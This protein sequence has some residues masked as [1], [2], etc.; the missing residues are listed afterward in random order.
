ME[1]PRQAGADDE[2]VSAPVELPEL[3]AASELPDGPRGTRF[4]SA[5]HEILEHTDFAAWRTAA[6]LAQSEVALI[7]AKLRKHALLSAE[8]IATLP[9]YVGKLLSATLRTR[10]PCGISLAEL[11]PSARRAELEFYF[12]FASVHPRA[13]LSLLQQY[14]YQTSRLDFARMRGQLSGLM[15]GTIDLVFEHQGRFYLVDYKT[16]MLGL[17][18]ADYAPQALHLAIR[19]S[20]YDL[21]YLIYTLALHRWLKQVF[22]SAYHYEQQFGEAYYLFARGMRGDGSTGIYRDRPPL[23]LILALDALFAQ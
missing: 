22:G 2:P 5:L 19:A 13:L 21:Q 8:N 11:A 16:N 10:L 20:D 18:Y 15:N 14:G 1:L 12:G 3:H 17:N 9:S 23:A 4:G 7:D 6:P